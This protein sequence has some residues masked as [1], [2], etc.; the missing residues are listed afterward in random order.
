MGP[1][2]S[3]STIA[4]LHRGKDRACVIDG[5]QQKS[6][7]SMH[8]SSDRYDMPTQCRVFRGVGSHRA[9]LLVFDAAS[10]AG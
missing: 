7:G 10:T 5:S 4:T 9:I 3:E 2:G 1:P 6:G 8:G